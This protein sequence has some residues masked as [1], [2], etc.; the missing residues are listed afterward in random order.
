MHV[1]IK[2]IWTFLRLVFMPYQ[3][4]L[5]PSRDFVNFWSPEKIPGPAVRSKILKVVFFWITASATPLYPLNYFSCLR[6]TRQ[7]LHKLSEVSI[8]YVR[9]QLSNLMLSVRPMLTY[10]IELKT[11]EF[12]EDVDARPNLKLT[13]LYQS[14]FSTFIS[15][16]SFKISDH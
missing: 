2:L 13:F 9:F 10:E 16:C 12:T 15:D 11:R 6:V 5:L 1:E 8:N 14:G 3:N 7:T 4:F